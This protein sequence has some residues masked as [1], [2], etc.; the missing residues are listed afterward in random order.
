NAGAGYG[1]SLEVQCAVVSPDGKLAASG[2]ADST[3]HVWEAT[4]GKEL[5]V[6]TGHTSA[7]AALV[8]T[9][10]SK[11]L[12]SSGDQK[13]KALKVWDLSP[14]AAPVN[15]LCL[16]PDRKTLV[17][18]DNQGEVKIWNLAERKATHTFQASKKKV[19]G[20]SMGPDGKRFA[21]TSEDNIV[22]LWDV[23]SGQEL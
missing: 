1:H 15:D 10:D 11:L 12:I 16:T 21:T 20:F 4:T 22:K 17:T 7:V 13:D 19:V 3:V 14:H 18:A 2:S 5:Y 8:F 6:L 23:A 9:S